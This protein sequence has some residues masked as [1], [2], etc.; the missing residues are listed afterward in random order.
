MQGV[1][2]GSVLYD[3][4]CK[5]KR[6]MY[7]NPKYCIKCLL[8]ELLS[9]LENIERCCRQSTVQNQQLN[10]NI[11]TNPNTTMKRLYNGSKMVVQQTF[12]GSAMMI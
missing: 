12:N 9:I 7:R 11:A 3:V 4:N 1:Q 2:K 10:N 8:H 5:G 6:K